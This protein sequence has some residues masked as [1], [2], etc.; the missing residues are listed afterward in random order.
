[1]G[2]AK[3]PFSTQAAKFSLYA[4][5][6]LFLVGLVLRVQIQAHAGTDTGRQ[7]G[8]ALGGLSFLT[9]LAAF[10]LGFVGLVGGIS[11]R[12]TRTILFSILGILLNGG[13][14]ALWISMIL[15]IIRYGR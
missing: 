8:I 12:A 10:G 13:L 4:P 6:I 5:F 15:A 3:E 1:M 14:I 11:R 9:T 7:M 2:D